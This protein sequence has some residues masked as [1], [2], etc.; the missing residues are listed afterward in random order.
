MRSCHPMG[1]G[2]GT[3][4]PCSGLDRV[5]VTSTPLPSPFSACPS[6]PFVFLWMFA[7]RPC[8]QSVVF[9]RACD[10]KYIL[11]VVSCR[12]LQSCANLR[13]GGQ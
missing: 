2:R 8:L 4:Q 1:R 5:R 10:L 9:D 13:L 12:G 7:L 6:S 11:V 3:L